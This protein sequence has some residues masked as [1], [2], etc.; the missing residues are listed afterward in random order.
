MEMMVRM[1]GVMTPLCVV[2]PR[3]AL[4]VCAAFSRTSANIFVNISEHSQVALQMFC[5]LYSH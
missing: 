4:M 3:V 1:Y 2:R 5:M